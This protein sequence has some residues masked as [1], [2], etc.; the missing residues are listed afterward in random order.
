MVINGNRKASAK[1]LKEAVEARE[2]AGHFIDGD[3][4]DLADVLISGDDRTDGINAPQPG[5][6]RSRM[7][8]RDLYDPNALRLPPKFRK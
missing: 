7:W 8:Y 5:V 4:D 6:W 2:A 1:L 3:C